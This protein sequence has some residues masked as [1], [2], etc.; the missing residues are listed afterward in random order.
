M[1]NDRT[2]SIVNK[3][4]GGLSDYS[5]GVDY[6]TSSKVRTS[7]QLLSGGQLTQTLEKI[8]HKQTII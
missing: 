8:Y 6:D 4:I 3:V 1:L 7:F 2:I 5:F